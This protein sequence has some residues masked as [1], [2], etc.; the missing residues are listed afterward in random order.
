M[1]RNRC[2]AAFCT[3]VGTLRVDVLASPSWPSAFD[4]QQYARKSVVMPHVCAPC[5]ALT[6]M[7]E[8]P[9]DTSLGVD[10]SSNVPSPSSP[11]EL[12]P[13]QYAGPLSTPGPDD[14]T[15]HVC[16]SPA[17]METKCRPPDTAKGWALVPCC[18]SPFPNRPLRFEPQQY[19]APAVV[20]AQEWM[21]PASTSL[22][23]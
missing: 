5:D 13:Q 10:R 22:N 9:P 14:V 23:S 7:N 2:V 6:L 15:P 20:T 18:G 16:L 21:L 1:E 11:F 3:S 4:P 8:S 17:L 19:A 12:F